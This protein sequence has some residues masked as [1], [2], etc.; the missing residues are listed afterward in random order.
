MKGLG[1]ISKPVVTNQITCNVD[2]ITKCEIPTEILLKIQVLQD[3]YSVSTGKDKQYFNCPVWSVA[4]C[5][6]GDR[7]EGRPFSTRAQARWI[8]AG[9]GKPYCLS[10]LCKGKRKVHPRTGHEGPEG[11]QRYSSTLSLTLALDG[12]WAG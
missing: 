2:C 5:C 10:I 9:S 4:S 6:G 12:V 11:E 7:M 1:Q 8:A 3:V